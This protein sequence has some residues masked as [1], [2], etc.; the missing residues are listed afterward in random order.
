M[1]ELFS[2]PT[3]GAFGFAAKMLV[4]LIGLAAL[5]F[6]HELGHFLAARRVGVEVE[7][8]SIGFGP[9]LLGFKSGGTEYLLAA[10]PLGGYVKMKG[11]DLEESSLSIK[12]SFAA[13]PPQHRL[14]IAFAGPLFNILFAIAIYYVI[15]LMGSPSLAP[16]VGSIKDGSPAQVAQLKTGDKIT[17]I[18]GTEIRFW[19]DL[20][21]VVHDAPGKKLS[22]TLERQSTLM[23]MS[24]TPM[25]EEIV[26][27][28]G[29]K[30]TVGLIGISPLVQNVTFVKKDS[31]ADKAGIQIGDKIIAVNGEP[32]HGWADLKPAAVDKP[33]TE[34]TFTIQRDGSERMLQVTPEPKT[35]EDAEGGNTTIGVIGVGLSG[36]LFEEK[37]GL[38]GAFERALEETWRLTYLI[39]VSIKK[40]ITGSIPSDSIGG[41]ILIFQIYG[42]QAEQG[43]SEF[44]RL[45]ALLSINLGLL[46]LLPIP[47]LDGGHIF[48]FLIELIKGKPVSERNRER[49]QHVGIVMLI[50]LMI[51]AFYNDIMRL[52]G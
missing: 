47:V 35:V 3:D 49:A 44:V 45:T 8:F 13:A 2:L 48:F 41:P 20:Q 52:I 19:E 30:E 40:M 36:Q 39:G 6:V 33:G 29:E 18:E 32:I 43:F 34:L 9:R 51:F 28:F 4:F 46:N 22:L 10:I 21:K 50:S 14:L 7:V 5:I 15:F 37:Y 23:D 24:I 17:M 27:L 42:E 26:N 25:A 12:G 11:E 31:A 1:F 16:V 38:W